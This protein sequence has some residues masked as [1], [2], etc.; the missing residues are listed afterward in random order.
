MPALFV[1]GM[2]SYTNESAL[3]SESYIEYSHRTVDVVILVKI[4]CSVLPVVKW[5]Q[6]R[7]KTNSERDPSYKTEVP[8][9]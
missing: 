3:T 2:S 4:Q 5:L 8:L 1:A 9:K 6:T 7:V